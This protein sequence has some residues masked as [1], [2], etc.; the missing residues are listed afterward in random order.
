MLIILGSVGSSS[1]PL[2]FFLWAW[3]AGG[4]RGALAAALELL[5]FFFEPASERLVE[6][7]RTEGARHCVVVAEENGLAVR[8]VGR[9]KNREA[10]PRSEASGN[11]MAAIACCKRLAGLPEADFGLSG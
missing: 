9:F 6:K 4:L 3:L 1:L 10:R 5:S 8:V 7:G 2:A 11:D